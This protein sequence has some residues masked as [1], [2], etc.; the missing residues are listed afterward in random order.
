MYIYRLLYIFIKIYIYCC[1]ICLYRFLN[2]LEET[3]K[4]FLFSFTL[5]RTY[6]FLLIPCC[7]YQRSLRKR[8][9]VRWNFILTL[10][11]RKEWHFLIPNSCWGKHLYICW[12]SFSPS[13][14]NDVVW[15]QESTQKKFLI[16]QN[17]NG[18]INLVFFLCFFSPIQRNVIHIS[19]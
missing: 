1:N 11:F 10:Q 18:C 3:K 6:S 15:I 2:L 5:L 16:H 14:V 19:S 8:K 4:C 12:Y 7:K 17:D 13:V 9:S